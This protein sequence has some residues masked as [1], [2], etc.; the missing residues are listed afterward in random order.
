MI[1]FKKNKD[2]VLDCFTTVPHVYE[3]AKIDYGIKYIPDW[4]KN[5]PK[6]LLDNTVTIKNCVGLMDFY[7]KGIVIPSWFEMDLTICDKNNPEWFSWSASNSDVSTDE[8]HSPEMFS[9]FAKDTGKNIKL[10]S[11]WFL[12]TKEEVYFSWTQPTWSMRPLLPYVSIL[13][14]VINFKYQH[15]SN[16][17]LFVDLKNNEQ[18]LTIPPLAPLVMMHPLTEK[19]VIIKTHLIDEKEKQKII[20]IRKFILRRGQTDPIDSYKK[21]KDLL[22]KIDNMNSGCPF[23]EGNV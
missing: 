20:G 23:N 18:Q 9:G 11:P 22:K 3:Y 7:K 17:N 2:V 14:A 12:K 19:N 5:T 1:F 4:W 13:P 16:I 21:K 10:Q 15:A 6:S 8:S